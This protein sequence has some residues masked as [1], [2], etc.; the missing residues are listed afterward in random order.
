MTSEI[1]YTVGEYEDGW[2]VELPSPRNIN[3]LVPVEGPFTTEMDAERWIKSNS[4]T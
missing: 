3:K 2:W 1:D 4:K